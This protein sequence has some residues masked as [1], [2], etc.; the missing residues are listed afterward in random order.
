LGYH[1]ELAET[2]APALQ[3]IRL[4]QENYIHHKAM[5]VVAAHGGREHIADVAP[6]LDDETILFK[7]PQTGY[8]CQARDAALLAA[9]LLSGR[10]GADFGFDHLQP[11][12]F[13]RYEYDS[14]GFSDA[15]RRAAALEK[16]RQ[17]QTA[18]PAPKSASQSPPDP[19]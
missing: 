2:L 6:Y 8:T 5:L 3:L 16:W 1:Y 13:H 12:E 17:L 11:N 19:R 15:D 7:R 14:I 9:V 18:E 10:Q 4:R